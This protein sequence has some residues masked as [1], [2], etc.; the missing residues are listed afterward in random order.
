M[1]VKPP[2][3]P[4]RKKTVPPLSLAFVKPENARLGAEGGVVS[5][6]TDCDW[7]DSTFPTLS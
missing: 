1:T 4:G 7:T 6:S 3:A 5:T 2:V